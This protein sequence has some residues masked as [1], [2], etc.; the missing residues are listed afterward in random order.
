MAEEYECPCEEASKI[1]CEMCQDRYWVDTMTEEEREMIQE[2]LQSS[3][4]KVNGNGQK[5]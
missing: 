5:S 3:V 1:N 4:T 2:L